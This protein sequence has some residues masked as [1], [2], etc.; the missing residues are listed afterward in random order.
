MSIVTNYTA[1][2]DKLRDLANENSLAVT[3]FPGEYPLRMTIKPYT[4]VGSQLSLLDNM[5]T[6]GI[7]PESVITMT[8]VDGAAVIDVNDQ[9][10]ISEALL[11]SF[12]KTFRKLCQTWAEIILVE[13]HSSGGVAQMELEDIEERIGQP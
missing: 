9:F 2:K 4:G 5:E 6:N 8:Y 12:S 10:R 13:I 3:F 1:A 11:A 7:K